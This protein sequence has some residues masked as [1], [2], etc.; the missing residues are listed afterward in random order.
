MKIIALV[1]TPTGAKQI[2]VARISSL[3]PDAATKQ[4]NTLMNILRL[5]VADIDAASPIFYP[6]S[7][8]WSIS[9]IDDVPN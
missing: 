2:L 9:T 1:D 6:P 4:A 8:I 3:D 5:G 7:R